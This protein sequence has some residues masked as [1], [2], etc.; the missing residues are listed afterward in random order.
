MG[1]NPLQATGS[2]LLSSAPVILL[3]VQ[4]SALGWFPA[5]PSTPPIPC[6]D[7]SPMP[8]FSLHYHP[9]LLLLP[10]P[11]YL[12]QRVICDYSCHFLFSHLLVNSSN[13]AFIAT[14]LWKQ[15]LPD[16][17]T[18]LVLPRLIITPRFSLFDIGGHS[19]PFETIS[20]HSSQFPS[21]LHSPCY[22]KE[23]TFS[24]SFTL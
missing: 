19:F 17:L 2:L 1:L 12:L 23:C 4:S 14:T 13:Q 10:L 18:A 3:L 11:L 9:Y 15:L 5:S 8:L 21:S 20:L 6:A 16:S 7:P 24:V 22:L